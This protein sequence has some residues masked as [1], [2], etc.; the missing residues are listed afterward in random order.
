MKGYDKAPDH[1]QPVVSSHTSLTMVSPAF[2]N[3]ILLHDGLVF[4]TPLSNYLFILQS[5][6]GE[7]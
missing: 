6:H 2:K 7:S 4:T 1:F 5:F 3:D